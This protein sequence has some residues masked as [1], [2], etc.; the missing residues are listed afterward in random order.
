MIIPL[1]EKMITKFTVSDDTVSDT[2]SEGVNEGIIEGISADVKGKLLKL[3]LEL[4][5]LP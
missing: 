3:V 5:C 1:D 4:Q 2:V